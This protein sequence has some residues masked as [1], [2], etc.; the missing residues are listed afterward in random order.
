MGQV[1]CL[2]APVPQR[3]RVPSDAPPK[4]SAPEFAFGGLVLTEAR[5]LAKGRGLTVAA[6]IVIHGAVL[7][8]VLLVPILLSEEPLPAPELAV[9]AF[10]AA[11]PSLAPAP[12]PPPPPALASRTRTPAA[13]PVATPPPGR[14]VAPVEIPEQIPVEEGIDM[15]VEGG[16]PGGVEGGVPGG[17]VGGIIGGLPAETPQ[18]PGPVVRIGGNIRAPKLVHEVPP[19]YPPLA[20]QARVSGV[21]VMEAHVGTDGHVRSVR[22]VSGNPILNDA[23]MEAVKQRRYQP[24]LLNG[25]PTEFL[26]TMTMAFRIMPVVPGS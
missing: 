20:I 2:L 21:V 12:P 7:V 17:V 13:T 14:F 11:P 24:L 22:V 23:A 4:R 5:S 9:R 19:A 8:A 10:F 3:P 1:A 18:V 26:L 25:V 15:G 16:V 6:S